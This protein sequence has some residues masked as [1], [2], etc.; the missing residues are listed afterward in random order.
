[1]AGRP[2][3]GGR[4]HEHTG[5]GVGCH[6]DDRAEST[7]R[8]GRLSNRLH[9]AL[10]HPGELPYNQKSIRIQSIAGFPHMPLSVRR[11]LLGAALVLALA[12]SVPADSRYLRVD[13][14]E[15]GMKGVGRTVFAGDTV[16]EFTVEV[17]GVLRNVLGP[18]RNLI[19]ARLEGGPLA[20]TGVIA[21]M[22]G[23]P[24][25]IDGRLVGAVSYALGAFS[26]EPIAGI[27][28]IGEMIE[29]AQLPQR[30]PAATR[31]RVDL[32]ITPAS[33]TEV[34]R[35]AFAPPAFAASAAHVEVIG[36]Q[37][38]GVVA[39]DLGPRLRPIATPLVLGGFSGDVN[40]LLAAA[41]VESGFTP[42]TGMAGGS[43]PIPAAQRPL[44][45]GDAVGVNL[46]AGDLLL[47]GTGTVTHVDED[48]VYAFGHPFYNLGP[49][50]FP[51]TRAYVHTLLPSL[52]SSAKLS[53]T[54]DVIGTFRQDRATTI[55]GTL[56]EGPSMLPIRLMLETDRGFRRAFSFE[57][58]R[59]QLFT[60]LLTYFSV[61]NTLQSY[62]RQYGAATFTVK[63]RA[64][65]R[66]HGELTFED[67][68]T[69]ESPSVGAASAIAVPLTFLLR[70][71]FEPV[72]IEALDITITSSEE[73]RTAT[74]ERIWLDTTRVRPG[75]TVPLKVLM[76]S[77]RGDEVAREIPLTIPA[78]AT[79]QL[80][81]MV[82]DG[83][84]LAQ[85]EQREAGRQL[86]QVHG[87]AQMVRAL[88]EARRN[89]RLYVRLLSASEG[90]VVGGEPLSSL[91]PS[92]LS[93]LESDRSGGTFAPLRNATLGE[94]DLPTDY[95]VTGA[96]FL[97]V[98][99]ERP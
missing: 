14:L 56:G 29:A 83:V 90:A 67:L 22:S 70:N 33:F 63:G 68:F 69:G 53:T 75:A 7:R 99:L 76:R 96:R 79:G 25:Y 51:M 37:A 23:S 43:G 55:A 82:A 85:W 86:Q 21:G 32:P 30:R 11:L 80:T 10:A 94:W 40:D 31:A 95:A 2:A 73:P 61:L 72:D 97:T 6:S 34:V 57:V 93:V 77:Y 26:K 65:V 1:M 59:D 62:E 44:Q 81:I 66:H 64:Q 35:A 38:D 28:P 16:E 47:G 41:F 88:N 17:L 84:R 20:E 24:V 19:L 89:N 4:R 45:P 39:P 18:S 36:G 92:V 50:E 8:V 58:V 15:P 13:E 3:G 49:T 9:R 98:S 48:R 27:T 46:I 87:L 52:F 54:G 91:P 5:V 78:N 42:L 71:E 74:I 60:P 12:A